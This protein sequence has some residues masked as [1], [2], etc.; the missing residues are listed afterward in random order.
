MGHNGDL[1]VGGVLLLSA[2]GRGEVMDR[3]R[4]RFRIRIMVKWMIR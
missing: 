2:L 1:D 3:V 4:L